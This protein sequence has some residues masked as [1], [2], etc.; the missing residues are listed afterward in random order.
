MGGRI[1]VASVPG[2]GSCFSFNATMQLPGVAA[3]AAPGDALR[4]MRILVVDDH[5]TARTILH[6]LLAAWGLE[7][8]LAADGDEAIALLQAADR[9]GEPF[10]L[11]LLDWQMPGQSGVD[12]LRRIHTLV[13]TRHLSWTPVVTMITAHDQDQLRADA[14]ETP[15]DFVLA[16]P[17]V[18]SMLHGLLRKIQN[19][20]LA[21][22]ADAPASAM[23]SP[24]EL[25]APLQGAHILVVEDNPVNQTVIREFLE[26]AR[27]T[28]TTAGD[29]AEALAKLEQGDFA[30]VLMDVH[31]PVM[32][33]LEATR[34]I[35]QRERWS[36]LPVIALTAAS[37]SEQQAACLA[38]GM[39]ATVL[40][41]IGPME[42]ALILRQWIAPRA[43]N[44]G[45]PSSQVDDA[46]PVD[47]ETMLELRRLQGVQLDEALARL[48]GNA[49][50]YRRLLVDFANR[51]RALA[52][53]DAAVL[54]A[55]PAESLYA[56]LHGL[57]GEA[58]NLGW[59]EIA[60]QAKAL[61]ARVKAA[62]LG[63]HLSALQ[64][65]LTACSG[66]ISQVD[67]LADRSAAQVG[68]L[69]PEHHEALER[70][71]TQLQSQLDSKH[72]GAVQTTQQIENLLRQS[73]WSAAYGR[74]GDA[75]QSLDYEAAKGE[76]ERFRCQLAGS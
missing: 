70:L 75:V 59:S 42:L 12:T 15:L 30:A 66:A 28:V 10:E 36:A 52:A 71:L 68:S 22:L 38:A 45:E 49:G 5:E 63:D 25:L 69:A 6:T 17:I 65:L 7:V 76:L 43:N 9:R 57:Q 37:A 26:R 1:E 31:M 53:S 41:P 11:L 16:K 18:P 44:A 51:Y 23:H 54:A 29:G 24:R 19:P 20:A 35:R 62:E 73:S 4:P 32:D 13:E 3:V 50:L 56:I 46:D 47:D 8:E 40:K 58:G 72:F 67:G 21:E 74:L 14:G 34:Q 55:E 60:R 2:K 61:A 33:G 48:H 27:L 64:T 39:N